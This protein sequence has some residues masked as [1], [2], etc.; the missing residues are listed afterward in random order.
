MT[1]VC[2]LGFTCSFTLVLFQIPF[3]I[4]FS[5]RFV[6]HDDRDIYR[7]DHKK[8]ISRLGGLALFPGFMCGVL[9]CFGRED[10]AIFLLTGGYLVMFVFGLIDDLFGVEAMV[11]ASG[12]IVSA[13]LI[14]G[15][16]KFE[17]GNLHD[18]LQISQG[19]A[20]LA[21]SIVILLILLISN[22]FNMIDGIDGLAGLIGLFVHL[23]LGILLWLGGLKN[24]SLL[25]VI[26]AGAIAGFLYHNINPAKIFM[27]DSGAM[28]IGLSVA[29]LSVIYLNQGAKNPLSLHKPAMLSALLIVPVFD[30]LRVFIIR[31]WSGKSPFKGDRNHLHHQLKYLG[32]S[33]NET[34]LLLLAFNIMVFLFTVLLNQ[35]GNLF[36]MLWQCALCLALHVLLGFLKSFK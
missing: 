32:L 24:Y 9:F 35:F 34:V 17:A 2:F 16:V 21:H 25:S 10:S 29:I 36:L 4:R 6:L 13:L 5:N 3:I 18:F 28:L 31:L 12:Q 8:G 33:D 14:L 7:K 1:W 27:G 19:Y 22:S 15:L 23:V 30:L 11:K 20:Y 26:M